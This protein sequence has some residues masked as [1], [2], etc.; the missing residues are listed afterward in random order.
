[1]FGRASTNFAS[2]IPSGRGF[3]HCRSFCSNVNRDNLSVT[4]TAA[5]ILIVP[6]NLVLAKKTESALT[7]SRSPRVCQTTPLYAATLRTI[8]G[9]SSGSISK[10]G[11]LIA[12]LHSIGEL[13]NTILVVSSDNGMPFPRCKA[14]LYD[15]GTRVPLA[16]RWGQKVDRGSRIAD[17]VSLCDL[18]PTFLRAA[19]IVPPRQMT[20]SSLLPLL[21]SKSSG[22]IDPKRTFVLAGM[23]RH[24]YPYPSRSL[25]TKDFL[26]LRNF[27]PEDWPTGK[28][29]GHDPTYDFSANPWP[30]EKGAFSFNIDPSPTKQFLR[31]NRHLPNVDRYARLAFDRRPAEELYDLRKDPH[32]IN[33]VANRPAY[34][35]ILDEKRRKLTAELIKSSDPRMK[36][37]RSR[38][39]VI[40][41]SPHP[42]VG[43]SQYDV[44]TPPAGLGLDPFYG[45]YVQAGGY[46]IV[47]SSRV[48][49]YAL[50]EA[51][52]LVDMMLAERP[53]IRR[54]MIASGSR[55]IV[56][57][58]DEYTTDVPEHSHLRPKDYMDARARG[59][60]GSR[61]DPVCSVAEENLL[62]FPGDPYSTEN[63]L[64]HEFAHNIHLRG[65]V[66]IDPA[67]DGR[68]KA[69]YRRAM[70]QGLWKGKY[71]S[72]NPAE[73]FAEGVQ[74]WFD[75]NRQ[76]DHDHNHV[77]TRDELREYDPGLARI[78][79]SVFGTTELVYTKPST[80]LTG[81]LSGYDPS[82]APTF[83]WPDRLVAAKRKFARR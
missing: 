83:R 7:R 20:G 10:S 41:D 14:T 43:T 56:M 29:A 34:A 42:T 4:G 15:Q 53:D 16:I 44:K 12:T 60:G 47:S 37:T 5:R 55:M 66:N 45:K 68:L 69:C 71:A 11:S 13:E 57:A 74:S 24:V 22:Q 79:A 23:E 70:D 32:Q 54:A 31:L 75:N 51:A 65:M 8:C 35:N 17:F 26:Y 3:H 48:N 40:E 46:P 19:G 25:R 21:Q 2:E 82:T 67:F 78:C 28:V 38:D 33:N 1:M 30:T 6:T 36:I 39:R 80:R 81:H 52:Y 58:H 62:G 64:I 76:P 50:K 61:T 9:K 18:A 49:D 72:T 73:Y 63:I 59:L 27:K 77:D